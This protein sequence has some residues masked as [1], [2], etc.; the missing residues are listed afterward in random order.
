M[1]EEKQL[2]SAPE[3]TDR[4]KIEPLGYFES[5]DAIVNKDYA[6]AVYKET[7]TSNNKWY[8]KIK[9]T[10]TAGTS[11]D[12]EHP[13]VRKNI[14][15]AAKAGKDYIVFGF[16]LVPKGDDPR[17]V[18]NRLYFNEDLNP[19]R[20]SMHLITRNGDG[21]PTEEQ[22]IKFDWPGEILE[23]PKLLTPPKSNDR[24]KVTELAYL[25]SYDVITDK[26][27]AYL[28]YK[29]EKTDSGKWVLRISA[30]CTAGGYIDPEHPSFK[31]N[32]NKAADSGEKYMIFGF[33]MQPKGDDPR[34]VE[35]RLYF[36]DS[37]SP[38][39]IEI[40]VVTR[41][42]DGSPADKQMAKFDWPA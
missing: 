27:Y 33:N 18:E 37:R 41:K 30:K 24:M 25:N 34:L 26:D 3:S 36:N 16:N 1:S 31:S 11:Y 21:S 7:N 35:N 10:C 4:A 15:E 6:Y 14:S 8:L 19:V 32:L 20:V 42:A 39:H 12:P 2:V 29:E 9:A 28:A 40:H 13:S 23:K 17:L 38:T 5:R 22:T